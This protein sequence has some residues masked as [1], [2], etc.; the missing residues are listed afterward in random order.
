MCLC[1]QG[2]S[3]Y[4]KKTNK[5]LQGVELGMLTAVSSTQ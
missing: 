3:G 1:G 5:K 4:K 2:G